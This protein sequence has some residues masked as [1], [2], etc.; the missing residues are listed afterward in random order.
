MRAVHSGRAGESHRVQEVPGAVVGL[1]WQAGSPVQHLL[2]LFHRLPEVL[3]A[4]SGLPQRT[5]GASYAS[6][7]R[8][9]ACLGWMV[10]RRCRCTPG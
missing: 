6:D 10:R 9:T 3:Q 1:G 7:L 4:E 5:V 2:A 8:C